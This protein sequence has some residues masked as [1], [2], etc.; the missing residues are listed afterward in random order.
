[1]TLVLARDL[2]EAV[3]AVRP[4][5]RLIEFRQ[6]YISPAVAPFADVIRAND[7]PA[8]ADQNRRSTINLRML[9]IDQ[10]VHSDP[11]MWDPNGARWRRCRASC[12]TPFFSVPSAVRC[13]WT[14]SLTPTGSGP[15]SC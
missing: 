7:C 15:P 1:M 5:S 13:R 12:S 6:P 9:A 3:D 8:D 11:V 2:P 4:R 10:T 14:S